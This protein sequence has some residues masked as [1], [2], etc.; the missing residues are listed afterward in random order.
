MGFVLTGSQDLDISDFGRIDAEAAMEK[1]HDTIDSASDQDR[2][3][4]LTEAGKRIAAVVP[5]EVAEYYEQ[6]L[7][8]TLAVAGRHHRAAQAV[9]E[10][11]D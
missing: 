7:A 9:P 5:V 3:T 11:G 10:A 8:G 1:L 2:I 4:W 6:M